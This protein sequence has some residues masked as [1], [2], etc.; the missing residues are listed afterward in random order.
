[1]SVRLCEAAAMDAAYYGN[2]EASADWCPPCVAPAACEL[3]GYYLCRGCADALDVLG[4]LFFC[5]TQEKRR[6]ARRMV[7]AL[8]VGFAGLA[9]TGAVALLYAGLV[10]KA[11][12][13]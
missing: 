11:W 1:V 13:S 2:W 10:L 8:R 12:L 5:R 9:L 4:G 6:E 7:L 3:H